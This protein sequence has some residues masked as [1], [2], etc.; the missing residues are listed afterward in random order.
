MTTQQSKGSL[1]KKINS[2]KELKEYLKSLN[3]D[4]G[5]SRNNNKRR[6]CTNKK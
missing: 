6:K 4:D 1:H 5:K 2:F 3:L